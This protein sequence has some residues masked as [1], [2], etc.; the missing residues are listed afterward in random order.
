MAVGKDTQ[1]GNA[2]GLMQVMPEWCKKL[3]INSKFDLHEIDIGIETG[4]RV[5]LIHL[6]EAEGDISKALYLYVN[7]DKTYV[8]K[9][10]SEIGKFIAFRSVI[11]NKNIKKI[12]HQVVYTKS[13]KKGTYK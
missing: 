7:K 2:R 1:H 4:I 6:G 5:F 3:N 12:G 8:N 11:D 9:V 10:Y 13:K